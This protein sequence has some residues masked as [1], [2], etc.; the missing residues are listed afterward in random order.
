VARVGIIN[1]L[2]AN[3]FGKGGVIPIE[4][5]FSPASSFMELKLT[6]LQGD[7]MK[8]SMIVAK[9]LAWNNLSHD[10][11]IKLHSSVSALSD[12]NLP[13]KG[14]HVHCPEG[15]IPKDGPSAGAA[16]TIAM[17]SLFTLTKIKHEFAITGEVNLQG[18]ITQIGGLDLKIIG[19]INAGVT[20][21]IYPSQ[22]AFDFDKFMHQYRN[23]PI[24]KD[25]S[26]YPVDN[27]SQ[28]IDLIML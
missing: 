15:S 23:D 5:C 20:N 21:F 8:E 12:S 4:C 22:N 19:G 24:I 25:I 27:I 7:I 9:T 17:F 18:I 28:V 10:Q 14:I 11:I 1:G 26:F 6:G 3:S 13:S 2:W 16:I